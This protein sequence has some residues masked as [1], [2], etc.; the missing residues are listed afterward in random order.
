M[1]TNMSTRIV[2]E[3][4]KSNVRVM[5]RFAYLKYASRVNMVSNLM[6]TIEE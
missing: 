4:G 6:K 2:G 5:R 1:L 3:Y